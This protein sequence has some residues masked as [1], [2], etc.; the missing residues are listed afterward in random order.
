MLTHPLITR[1]IEQ[2]QK[3]VELQNF[4]SRKRLLEYDDVMN[5][6]REVIYSLR[7][8]RA[9]GRRGA[10]G[11]SAEDGRE[12]RR[13]AA[14]RRVLAEFEDDRGVGL[15]APAA[16]AA[17]ALPAPGARLRAR[18]PRARPSWPTAQAK[19]VE[20]GRA[21]FA[22]KLEALDMVRDQEGGYADR[23]L[24]YVMLNV[25][26]EKWKDHLYDLDQLRNAIHYRSWGQKDPLIEYKQEAY[27]MFVDLMND[28]AETFTRPVP[29]GAAGDRGG[30][31]RPSTAV[32]RPRRRRRGATTRSACSRT[33]RRPRAATARAR[34]WTSGRPRRRRRSRPTARRDPVIVGAGKARSMSDVENA[35]SGDAGGLVERRAQR[36]L[37]VWLGEEVQEVPRGGGVAATRRWPARQPFDDV[38]RA[39]AAVDLRMPVAV[40]AGIPV[41]P[42]RSM[43]AP[44]P[45][46]VQPTVLSI[47]E[48]P[49]SER[50]RERLVALGAAALSSAEL[51]ALLV[52]AGPPAGRR[53]RWGRPCSPAPAARCG[54]WR[55]S[56]SP[57]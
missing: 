4:Q 5:Q 29:Q 24:R 47:R 21:A 9:R 6:Q 40:A 38:E 23:L 43:A 51:L 10:E 31:V 1:S 41:R 54:G 12:G 8:V 2:A 16:G 37:S 48:L 25:L 45:I 46:E 30:A 49:P 13:A 19:A 14:S 26:D 42:E 34:C 3:R 56:R 7:V 57:R 33:S 35:L 36:S 20:A 28:V 17:D 22:G 15:R 18:R 32:P 44:L 55:C 39:P 11:R 27:S 53:S 52:G 50:P